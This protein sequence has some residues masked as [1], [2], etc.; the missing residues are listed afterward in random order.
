GSKPTTAPS[1]DQTT[2]DNTAP[3][4]GGTTTPPA[5]QTGSTD[6]SSTDPAG[7]TPPADN[8]VP[9]GGLTAVPNDIG[10]VVNQVVDAVA[11]PVVLPTPT[12]EP[13]PLESAQQYFGE[14][15]HSTSKA[16][17][18]RRTATGK[19][20]TGKATTGKSSAGKSSAKTGKHS[21][22]KVST[23]SVR[24]TYAKGKHSTGQYPEGKH[25]AID[26]TYGS[27]EETSLLTI[28]GV[29]NAPT[30]RK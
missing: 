12:G 2:G 13:S 6:P 11:A 3:T 21:T 22:G 24:K 10:A 5:G 17:A 8:P 25:A 29:V 14:S 4:D 19:A 9:P 27:T 15:H 23:G 1:S 20:A 7:T 28:L 16:K 30:D 18:T 26:R